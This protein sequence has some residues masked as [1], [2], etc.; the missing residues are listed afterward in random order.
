MNHTYVTL[1]GLVATEPRLSIHNNL[2][3]TSFRLVATSR[4]YDAES[5][6]WVDGESTWVTVTCFRGLATH[7]YKSL[8][9]R[10]RVIVHG[11]LATRE[12][13][14]QRR[15]NVEVEADGI[16][17]DLTFGTSSFTRTVGVGSAGATDAETTEDA[18][19]GQDGEASV[20]VA[21]AD[22]EPSGTLLTD[23]VGAEDRE[24]VPV[25]VGEPPF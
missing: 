18:G 15:V 3:I 12:W 8:A 20:S 7:A 2:P 24:R 1:C 25:L 17:H 9:K 4:R 19:D 22:G 13:G 6:A 21:A 23:G 16:G 5:S 14:E 10:D 11:R